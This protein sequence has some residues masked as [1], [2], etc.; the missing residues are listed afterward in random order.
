MKQDDERTWYQKELL[1]PINKIIT[2]SKILAIT[3]GTR[4]SVVG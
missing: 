2:I 1:A 4:G 3:K